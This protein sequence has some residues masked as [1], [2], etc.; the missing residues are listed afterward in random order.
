MGTMLV[1]TNDVDNVSIGLGVQIHEISPDSRLLIRR[2]TADLLTE[3]VQ[4][5]SDSLPNVILVDSCVESLPLL[6]EVKANSH[7]HHIPILMLRADATQRKAQIELAGE[8]FL[9]RP[10]Q[11]KQPR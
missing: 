9:H 8:L 3:L 4:L 2:L 1:L 7:L 10:S 11:R 5:P 6:K